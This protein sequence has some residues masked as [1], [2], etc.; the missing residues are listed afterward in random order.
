MEK[1]RKKPA[2][3][4][5]EQFW[6]FER[7]CPENVVR[8]KLP[9]NFPEGEVC[10]HCGFCY[11]DHGWLEALGETYMVCPGDMVIKYED[12]RMVA[13]RPDVFAMTYEK[14]E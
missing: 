3:I 7:A 12:G 8:I 11:I 4:E 2:V 1:F 14:V 6:P 10:S 13:C 9:D 5:A